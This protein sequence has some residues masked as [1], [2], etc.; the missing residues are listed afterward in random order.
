MEEAIN[1]PRMRNTELLADVYRSYISYKSVMKNI[2]QSHISRV[3]EVGNISDIDGCSNSI[4]ER[5]I[6]F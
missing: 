4:V 1:R 3:T 6:R 2:C 5:V